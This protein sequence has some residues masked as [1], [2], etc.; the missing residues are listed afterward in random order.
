MSGL[1]YLL[2]SFNERCSQAQHYVGV[3]S[4]GV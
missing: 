2:L 4:S 1:V 3:T